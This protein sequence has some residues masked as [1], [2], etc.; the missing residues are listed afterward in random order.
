M[1][2]FAFVEPTSL[3]EVIRLLAAGQSQAR[4]IAGGSDLLGELKDDV[5]AYERLVSLAGVEALRHI[6][7]ER[8]ATIRR[9][10]HCGAARI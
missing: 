9:A 6:R 4:L 2:P 3:D 10:G 8:E 5:V 1:R 7:Q